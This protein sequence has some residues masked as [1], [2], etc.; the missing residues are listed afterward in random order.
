MGETIRG[1]ED[2]TVVVGRNQTWNNYGTK[3]PM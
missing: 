3:K 1:T 2:T